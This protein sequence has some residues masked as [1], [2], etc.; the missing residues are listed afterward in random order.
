MSEPVRHESEVVQNVDQ[1]C[2]KNVDERE[3]TELEPVQHVHQDTA[4]RSSS[5]NATNTSGAGGETPFLISL[6]GWWKHYI[7]LHVPHADCRDH[8][9]NERTFLAYQRT[10]LALSMLG[11]VTAQLFSLQRSPDP[12]NDPVFGY[13]ALGKPLAGLFQSAAI[14]VIL[15]G[16]HRFWRQQMN[17][18]RGKVWAGGWEI[19][20]IMGF[21][22]LVTFLL[23]GALAGSIW[24]LI[25]SLSMHLTVVWD[26]VPGT[27][28]FYISQAVGWGV[29]AALFT[30]AISISGVSFRFGSTCHINHDDSMATFWGWLLAVAG[31]ALIVQITTF[32]YCLRVFFN[33]LWEDSA[34][35]MSQGSAKSLPMSVM[36]AKS[37]RARVIYR[38]LKSVLYLQWR[39]M[40]IVTIVLVD[41]IFF[42]VV[43]VYLDKIEVSMLHDYTRVLP[44]VICLI[45]N[46]G[47]RDQCFKFSHKWLIS[48]PTIGAM[49]IMISLLGIELFVLLFRWS[50]I[51][52]W[53]ERWTALTKG[54]PQEF[55]SLDARK[56][57]FD[58]NTPTYELRKLGGRLQIDYSDRKSWDPHTMRPT[59]PTN[60]LDD[61]ATTP[62]SPA[63]IYSPLR[64]R[65]QQEDDVS[66]ITPLDSQTR[67]YTPPVVPARNFSSPRIRNAQSERTMAW[68]PATSFA[69][70]DPAIAFARGGARHMTTPSLPPPTEFE[71]RRPLSPPGQ[72]L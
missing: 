10:S 12:K 50:L 38:R 24:I 45:E 70:S 48:E 37:Q 32:A 27:R 4:V 68:D 66:P 31:A 69:S 40:L 44:W 60:L 55:V 33:S 39:G 5:T 14:V 9:A 16:G 52:A 36:S 43:F 3:A 57:Q 41:V 59:S 56:A 7:Q 49:L 35:P 63:P 26:I 29:P 8:L 22:L 65:E 34:R 2:D 6:R 28:F 19:W 47:N 51:T 11:I 46:G 61:N 18:A 53:K 30:S 23:A 62:N 25:R 72:A 54:K 21:M 58:P 20:T 71:G 17:M 13:H 64:R 67:R 15:I 42:A 1:P